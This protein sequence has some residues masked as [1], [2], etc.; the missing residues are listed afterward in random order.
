MIT[1][2]FTFGFS[3]TDPMTGQLLRE[4]YVVITAPEEAMCYRLMAMLF[5]DKW[6]FAYPSV[7]ELVTK[8]GHQMRQHLS[9]TYSEDVGPVHPNDLTSMRNWLAGDAQ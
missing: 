5:G 6:A 7:D 4:R 1:K 8:N 9:I 2:A 3:H